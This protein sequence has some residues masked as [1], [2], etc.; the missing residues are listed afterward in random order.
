MSAALLEAGAAGLA[1]LFGAGGVS[2]LAVFELYQARIARFDP[3]LNCYTELRLEAAREEACASAARWGE[4][5]PLSPIDGAPIAVKANIAVAGMACHAGIAAYRERRA[6]ADAPVVRALRQAGAVVLGTLNMH[7]AALGATTDNPTFGK[8]HNPWRRDYTPGGSSGGSGAA[9]AAG[10]CAAALGTDTMGSV[11]IPSAYCGCVGFKPS[12]GVLS[13][14]GVVPLSPTLDHVG[15]HGR[16]VADIA[17]LLRTLAPGQAAETSAPL[18]PRPPLRL[19]LWS[20]PELGLAPAVAAGL[21]AVQ[22]KL[23]AAGVRFEPRVPP[24]YDPGKARRAG[25]LIA[26]QEALAAHRET[27]LSN[28]GGFSDA[29]RAMLA[30]AAS[31]TEAEAAAAYEARWAIEAAAPAAFEGVAA[32]LAATAPQTAFPFAAGAP[33]S[34]ADL[35]AWANLAGLPAIALFAGLS[36]E[37]LPLSIQLVGRGG[38]DGALLQLAGLVEAVVGEALWPP[39]FAPWA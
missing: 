30:W 10:L 36:P 4:G 13:L 11:R 9:V 26:E 37:D 7:E 22:A 32:L 38:E 18:G 21:A 8:T 24:G 14:E 16:R 25:L 27:L 35:T 15:V 3:E 12:P 23:E 29:F 19:G 39:R 17:A 1:R 33:A 5:R 31:R 2:P 28:P 34:Q 6:D 20:G